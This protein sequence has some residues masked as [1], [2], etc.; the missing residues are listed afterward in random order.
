M[1][2][3]VIVPVYNVEKYLT[4]CVASILNQTY[5]DFE[6]ILVD[7]GSTDSSGTLCDSLAQAD[8]RVRV[9][10]QENGGL[11]QA[12]NAG[13]EAAQGEYLTFIDSDDWVD[14]TYLEYLHSLTEGGIYKLSI[15][16][17][18]NH[19]PNG[20]QECLGWEESEILTAEQCMQAIFYRSGVDV[21]ACA[22][23]YHRSLF[24]SVRFPVGKLFEDAGTTYRLILQ[25]DKIACGHRSQYHYVL[26]KGSIVQGRFNPHKLDL[27]EMTDKMAADTVEQYPGLAQ[28]ALARQVYA[29]FSTLNQMLDITGCEAERQAYIDFIR[30]HRGEILRDSQVGRTDKAAVLCL[31]LG[32]GIYRAAWRAFL[33]LKKG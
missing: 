21:T 16:S 29:R 30:A 33:K 9:I 28:A 15:C 20:R 31:S 2:I 3:S 10:H 7:D 17:Q 32:Y 6:L 25:C 27:I 12:R 22:K 4:D 19:F 23:L 24:R 5:R 13:I 14:D 26:R 1:L 18:T 11:S 8:S